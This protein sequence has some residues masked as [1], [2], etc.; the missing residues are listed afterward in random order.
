MNIVLASA[1]PRR[2]EILTQSGLSFD[3]WTSKCSEDSSCTDPAKL[4]EELA[5]KKA[6]DVASQILAYVDSHEDVSTLQDTLIIGADTIV[7]LGD[8]ILGKP[9]DESDASQMLSLLSG[10]THSV[11]TGVCLCFLSADRRVG[12]HTFCEETGVEFYSLTTEEIEAYVASGDPLDKAGAYGIQGIFAKH[13]K[14]IN[15]DYLNVVGLPISRIFFE[16]KELGIN[17]NQINS[18]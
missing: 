14:G 15:G 13:V 5:E 4:C 18:Q 11:Y 17:P 2:K 1:S 16:L 12:A 10:K 7:A 8:R 3:I 6:T 9:K